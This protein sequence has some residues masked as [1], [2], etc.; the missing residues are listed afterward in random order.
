V[1]NLKAVQDCTARAHLTCAQTMQ[2]GQ[3]VSSSQH[4]L[5]KSHIVAALLTL[6]RTC[7]PVSALHGPQL[8][9]VWLL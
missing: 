3:R 8:R 2:D 4:R 9:V 5:R 1:R 6:H 7:K